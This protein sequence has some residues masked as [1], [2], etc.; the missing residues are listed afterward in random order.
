M[1]HAFSFSDGPIRSDGTMRLIM[2]SALAIALILCL[3]AVA[4]GDDRAR[5]SSDGRVQGFFCS[6]P[7]GFGDCLEAC[8]AKDK[9]IDPY[10]ACAAICRKQFHC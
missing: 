3:P 9:S 10:R 2:K 1:L 5:F 7:K 6:A 8:A 4:C